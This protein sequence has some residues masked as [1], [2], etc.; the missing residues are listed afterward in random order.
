M[1]RNCCAD[2]PHSRWCA[3]CATSQA[4]LAA[5][6]NVVVKVSGMGEPGQ[7]WTAERNGGVVRFIIE[8]FGAD[9]CMFA[10]NFPVDSVCATHDQIA[11]GLKVIMAA[12][13]AASQDAFFQG[14]ARRVYRL[15]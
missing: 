9:R 14:T 12:F 5:C 3:A 13:P 15:A 1:R 4:A 6:P 11:V 7:A 10:S 8:A 2:R